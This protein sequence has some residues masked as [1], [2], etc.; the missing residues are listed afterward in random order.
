MAMA[1]LSVEINHDFA[2]KHEDLKRERADARSLQ[3]KTKSAKYKYAQ[4]CKLAQKEARRNKSTFTAAAVA[5]NERANPHRATRVAKRTCL[6]QGKVEAGSDVPT[7]SR[8]VIGHRKPSVSA[9]LR[10]FSSSEE[11]EEAPDSGK[12]GSHLWID[13]AETTAAEVTDSA[14]TSDSQ[15]S[16]GVPEAESVACFPPLVRVAPQDADRQTQDPDIA[17]NQGEMT[18]I[19]SAEAET[20]TEADTEAETITEAE[21]IPEAENITQA[22]TV[23][24]A[25]AC[26]NAESIM[27][28]AKTQAE[29]EARAIKAQAFVDACALKARVESQAQAK[30]EATL[31]EMRAAVERKEMPRKAAGFRHAKALDQQRAR[32][33]CKQTREERSFQQ[34]LEQMRSQVE[35][36]CRE[37][38]QRAE[39]EGNAAKARAVVEARAIRAKARSSAK[40]EEQRRKRTSEASAA[41]ASE[42]VAEQGLREDPKCESETNA[43]LTATRSEAT[44]E[45]V[46]FQ[47]ATSLTATADE[48]NE[49][50]DSSPVSLD[51]TQEALPPPDVDAEWEVLLDSSLESIPGWDVIV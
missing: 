12:F 23:T 13:D 50:L 18:E 42:V 14:E 1:S 38:K 49:P 44:G 31:A 48:E 32:R 8:G 19:S 16:V 51:D 29:S 26:A 2:M 37:V 5:A 24:M 33:Q 35:A 47:S 20:V 17:P 28:A 36:E 7:W 4:S 40:V 9:S 22:G 15:D 46:D 30:A 21:N 34:G 3:L 11:E 45:L 25:E 43:E 6:S 39:A 27:M 10:L 41:L